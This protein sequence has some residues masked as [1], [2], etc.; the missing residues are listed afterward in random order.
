V[1]LTHLISKGAIFIYI[2]DASPNRASLG[3]TNG[4]CQM[5]VSFMRAVGP[6]LTSSL[7]SVSLTLDPEG[8]FLWGRW[9]VYYI[10]FGVVGMTIWAGT[11][12]PDSQH[13]GKRGGKKVARKV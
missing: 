3:A 1:L 2:A 10:M 6:A 11:M 12:L 8:V 7:Y 4:L 13:V 5:L 9:M